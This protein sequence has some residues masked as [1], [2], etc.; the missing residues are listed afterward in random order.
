MVLFRTLACAALLAGAPCALAQT[1]SLED[2]L[3]ASEEESPRLAARRHAVS[4]A[5]EMVGRA[6]ELPDAKLRFGLENLPVNRANRFR[7]DQD[8][9]TMRA[10]GVMQ[11]FP[12]AAK[13][14]ARNLRAERARDL[15]T[16]GLA[17]ERVAVRRETALAW[18]EVHYAERALEVLEHL[19]GS[20]KLQIEAV[21]S[22][23]AAGRQNAAD[24]FAL[25]Q[26]EERA[27]DRV[28]E[29]R[30]QVARARIALATWIGAAAQ[31]PLGA[32]PD[33]ARLPAPREDLLAR[34]AAEPMLRVFGEREDLA[35]AEV[36]LARTTKESDWS[37]E[38]GYAQRS[39]SFSNMLTVMVTLDLPWQSERRQDRDVA[40]QLA[41]AERARAEREDARRT[42]EAEVR[43]WL[44]DFDAAAARL[45]RV[46][47]LQQ[48]LARE[49]A[50]AALAAYRGGRGELAPVLEAAR[51]QTETEL[52]L[53]GAQTARA[54]AWARLAHLY[55]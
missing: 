44:A 27:F 25:R 26:A 31:R 51:N 22:G 55:D 43:G 1:L 18:L 39:P 5:G 36:A 28:L 50:E 11:E 49:R 40:A 21:A 4:A 16:S 41:L 9:M 24:S 45:A 52:A 29:Q 17:A 37:L 20:F 38:V 46:E 34:L 15:E 35:R 10:I 33:T 30:R 13:R 2:V 8:F 23:V 54:R 42:R 6:G 47:S 3:R 19:A 12:N 7:F 53:V 48:P 14:E 32:A